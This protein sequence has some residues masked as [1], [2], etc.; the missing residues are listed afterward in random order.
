M[1]SNP[2]R[3]SFYYFSQHLREILAGIPSYGLTVIEAPS[4]FGKTTALR[5]YL[6]RE[7]KNS[8][9]TLVYLFRRISRQDMEGHLRPFRRLGRQHSG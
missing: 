7:Q 8:Q 3:N 4:G 6:T 5:E 2:Q 9:S 1:G